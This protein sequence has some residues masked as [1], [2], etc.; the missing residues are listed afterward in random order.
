MR[1]SCRQRLNAHNDRRRK[2][3]GGEGSEA[4]SSYR[5]RGRPR[6]ARGG[7]RGRGRRKKDSDEVSCPMP[8]ALSQHALAMGS[9]CS[10]LGVPRRRHEVAARVLCELCSS[11]WSSHIGYFCKRWTALGTS[12]K[13]GEP[14]GHRKGCQQDATFAPRESFGRLL[15]E[16]AQLPAPKK[17]G[18]GL[19]G[20]VMQQREQED[21]D[22]DDED[23]ACSE[24]SGGWTMG[25]R[26]GA[27][28]AEA[29]G[30]GDEG[31]RAR[32]HLRP[33]S[34]RA[35]P[36]EPPP[37]PPPPDARRVRAGSAWQETCQR[38]RHMSLEKLAGLLCG[39]VPRVRGPIG[40]RTGSCRGSGRRMQRR[41]PCSQVSRRRCAAA[42]HGIRPCS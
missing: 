16:A 26:R 10:L 20:L 2:R 12:F 33:R 1:R 7:R 4:R 28:P 31:G 14:P 11:L 13:G 37:P 3:V 5:G 40:W 21:G 36:A 30:S 19:P 6:N 22:S 18:R 9:P 35:A 15:R 24:D 23:E 39:S 41:H 29:G 38:S 25:G 27:E 34:A 32:Y 8:C 42:L 17:P